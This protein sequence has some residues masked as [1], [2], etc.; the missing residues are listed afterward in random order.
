MNGRL[1]GIDHGVKRLGIAVSD[2]TGLVAK[3]LCVIVRKSKAEDFAR[4][5]HLANEQRAVG[6][7]IGMPRNRDLP[8]G[9]YSQADT[10]QKWID[11]FAAT[12]PLPII[13]WEEAM[14]SIDAVEMA[15]GLRRQ[16]S[17]PIDDLAARVILQSYLDAVRDGLAAPLPS[18]G[19]Q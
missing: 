8:Q 17:Q 1:I 13:P 15:R 11:V 18:R 10:V 5:H 12:T 7:V 2:T 14:S 19:E 16:A 4:I 6:F 9:L 3:A